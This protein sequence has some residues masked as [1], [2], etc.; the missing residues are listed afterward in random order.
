MLVDTRIFLKKQKHHNGANKL[1]YEN[2]PLFVTSRQQ[3][4]EQLSGAISDGEIQWPKFKTK[5]LTSNTKL[6]KINDNSDQLILTAGL[7]LSPSYSS[8]YNTCAFA[9]GCAKVCLTSTGHGQDHMLQTLPNGEKIHYPHVAR[10]KR[11]LVFMEYRKQF[12][13][14]LI[15]EIKQHERIATKQGA[16]LAVRLNVFS[17]EEWEKIAPEL[18]SI[19][20][21]VIFYDYTKNPFRKSTPK[22]DLTF[23]Q[24]EI[25][26]DIIHNTAGNVA[27]VFKIK[28]GQPLP[29]TYKGKVVIDGDLH[30]NRFADLAV[31][32]IVGLRYKGNKTDT[33]NFAVT[34]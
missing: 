33:S 2:H 12:M 5:L 19:F 9:S 18:W 15:K 27:V 3:A 16:R 11:T 1:Y 23:S 4:R 7:Q 21:N 32:A 25:N 30:D 6:E 28:K 26:Q 29:L 14:Q 20:P 17:D 31:N 22:Y 13:A 24:N 8:G 34:V 10:I